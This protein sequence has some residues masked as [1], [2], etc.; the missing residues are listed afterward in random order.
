MKKVHP[1]TM[2]FSITSA[3][4]VLVSI[5]RFSPT[6]HIFVE[7]YNFLRLHEVIQIIFLISLTTVI[8]T[9]ILYEVTNHFKHLTS[10]F[11]FALT[12]TFI[13]GIYFYSTGNGVHEMASFSLNTYCNLKNLIGNQCKGL[14]FTDYYFGNI[15]Y[16]IGAF[17]MNLVLIFF[18]YKYP[19]QSFKRKG[20]RILIINSLIYSLAII[21][22]AGFDPA[23]IGLIFGIVT[24]I[25]TDIFVLNKKGDY[26]E[27]P[28]TILFA[29]AY[30][31]GTTASIVIRLIR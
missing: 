8:P 22:Y 11:G 14:F 5:E 28:V 2:L 12:L 27:I 21:A 18:E 9:F 17:L 16:F 7:P 4:V 20:M 31:I 24:T 3:I 19:N 1:L 29:I 23:P 25:I 30:T 26:N 13:I 6:A 15:L 10:K